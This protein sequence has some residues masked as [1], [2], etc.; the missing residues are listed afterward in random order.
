MNTNPFLLLVTDL[1]GRAGARR[2]E[3][4]VGPIEVKTDLATVDAA[5]PVTVQVRLEALADK[6]LARGDIAYSA[7]LRCNRCLTE[8]TE[9][10]AATF[11]QLFGQEPDVDT[12]PVRRDGHIDLEPTVHDEV[13]LALPMVP[14][15]QEDCLGLCPTCGTD[16]NTVPCAGHADE[17]D[18]PFSALQQFLEP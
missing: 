15:C 13:S 12:Q 1:L 7:D 17:S 9:T 11:T 14:L 10:G 4:I 18:S 16:L 2:N 8:W 5:H 6:V 3:T